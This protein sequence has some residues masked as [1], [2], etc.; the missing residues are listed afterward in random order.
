MNRTVL[1]LMGIF[2]GGALSGMFRAWLFVLAGQRLVARLR[3]HLFAAV[4]RQEVA[5]F[6]QNR[7]VTFVNN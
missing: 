6:D 2:F 4:I 5:F 7:S 3:K 1:I